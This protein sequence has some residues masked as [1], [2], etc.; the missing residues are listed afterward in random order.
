MNSQI[1]CASTDAHYKS[2]FNVQLLVLWCEGLEEEEEET[3]KARNICTKS[4][5]VGNKVDFLEKY[6]KM[7]K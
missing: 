4:K 2:L 1:L 3:T 7:D 6:Q 5:V